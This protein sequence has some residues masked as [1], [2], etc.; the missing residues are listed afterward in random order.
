MPSKTGGDCQLT[1]ALVVIPSRYNSS[2]PKSRLHNPEPPSCLQRDPSP[3][4]P[5]GRQ[6]NESRD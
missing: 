5:V 2:S 6:S 1:I 3:A 4:L